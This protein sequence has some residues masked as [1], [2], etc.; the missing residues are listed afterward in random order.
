ME[1]EWMGRAGEEHVQSHEEG[2]EWQHGWSS[3][4]EWESSVEWGEEV[5]CAGPQGL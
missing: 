3:E 1:G 4:D 5:E 2:K